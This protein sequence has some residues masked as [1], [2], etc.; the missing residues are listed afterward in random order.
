MYSVLKFLM[1]FL[2]G[3]SCI[4]DTLKEFGMGQ[5]HEGDDDKVTSDGSEDETDANLSTISCASSRYSQLY[6]S[7]SALNW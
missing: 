7:I 4:Q 6:N 1:Y 2:C 5:K 3:L